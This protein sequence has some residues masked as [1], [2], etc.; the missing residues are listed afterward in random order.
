MVS[1]N[2]EHVQTSQV[3]TVDWSQL[4]KLAK[5]TLFGQTGW[6]SWRFKQVSN[7]QYNLI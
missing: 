2:A 7:Y 3:K 1:L 4:A 5:L 6:K